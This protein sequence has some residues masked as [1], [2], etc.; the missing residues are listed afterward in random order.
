V[1]L[2]LSRLGRYLV[3]FTGVNY[4]LFAL[5]TIELS[6]HVRLSSLR[7]ASWRNRIHT[8]L[9]GMLLLGFLS[10]DIV[11]DAFGR[12]ETAIFSS[13]PIGLVRQ[14]TA[15]A[16]FMLGLP[17]LLRLQQLHIQAGRAEYHNLLAVAQA[18]IPETENVA[19]YVMP[20]RLTDYYL[21]GRASH[22]LYPRKVFLLSEPSAVS[23][24]RLAENNIGAVMAYDRTL[25][26]GE[27]KGQLVYQEQFR[28]SVSRTVTSRA[29]LTDAP[30]FVSAPVQFAAGIQLLGYE[31]IWPFAH[32]Q[33]LI[34]LTWQASQPISTSYTVFVH[35]FAGDSFIAQ[36]DSLPMLGLLPTRLWQPGM[37]VLDAHSLD[38]SGVQKPIT[39]FCLGLY[40]SAS[41]ERVPILF[42]TGYEVQDSSACRLF[43]PP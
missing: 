29:A 37:V 15:E 31:A 19:F 10:Y 39:R 14:V 5:Q 6:H 32:N 1:W 23:A 33:A 3:V 36:N 21:K 13:R 8:S 22:F 26:P 2:E 34:I 7:H 27:V 17:P 24:Q 4:L 43:S 38:L 35:A 40:D 30:E 18:L 42:A 20:A 16:A 11:A 9:V 25:Q 12:A 41:L 28:F